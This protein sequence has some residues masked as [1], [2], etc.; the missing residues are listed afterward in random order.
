MILLLPRRNAQMHCSPLNVYNSTIS[1]KRYESS[2]TTVYMFFQNRLKLWVSFRRRQW[3]IRNWE[4]LMYWERLREVWYFNED[5]NPYTEGALML[6]LQYNTDDQITW[7][8]KGSSIFSP[9]SCL[10]TLCFREYRYFAHWIE[11][12]VKPPWIWTCFLWPHNQ[13]ELHQG[14]V[15]TTLYL[16][17]A[18]PKPCTMRKSAPSWCHISQHSFEKYLQLSNILMLLRKREKVIL[19]ELNFWLAYLHINLKWLW[20][21]V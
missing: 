6:S 21:R 12:P 19:S 5:H 11:N 2:H 3:T 8:K 7:W 1:Q 17:W 15:S 16:F 20:W 9:M 13:V 4:N 14:E 10:P 18:K